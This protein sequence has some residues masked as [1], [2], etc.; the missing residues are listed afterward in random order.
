MDV[1]NYKK[2]G[3]AVEVPN[4]VAI[5]T[6]AYERFL[7]YGVA[8]EKRKDIGLEAIERQL[9][10]S[11]TRFEVGLIAITDVQEAQ[12]AFDRSVVQ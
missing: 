10:Q 3:D 7:Q 5:Q 1:R 12:A 9:E 6:D 4:L 2:V 8:P 11:Q